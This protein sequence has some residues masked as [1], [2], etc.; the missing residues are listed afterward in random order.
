MF[1]PTAVTPL[2]GYK[3]HLR[4]ADG[5]EGTVDLSHLAGQGVFA[6]WSDP[7]AFRNV[8]IGPSGEIQWSDQVDLC[9]DALYLEITGKT[10]E[11]VFPSLAGTQVHA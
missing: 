10:P 7:A 11:D 8:R 6:L 4:F 3:L 1:K 9:P 2:D 5:V